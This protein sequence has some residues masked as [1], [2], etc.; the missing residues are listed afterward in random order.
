MSSCSRCDGSGFILNPNNDTHVKQCL[1]AYA[2][3]LKANLGLEI[4]SANLITESPLYKQ[5]AFDLTLK[6]LYIRGDWD[7]LLSHFKWALGC[8][9]PMFRF[10]IVTDENLKTVYVGAESYTSRPR[11][12]RDGVQTHNSLGD[13]I[14]KDVELV[15]LR[16]GFIGHKN[17]AMPGILKEALRLREGIKKIT[18]IVE[19]PES[20][21]GPGHFSYSDEV[22]KYIDRNFQVLEL[23]KKDYKPQ[24]SSYRG[25][26]PDYEE[27][28][29]V[30]PGTEPIRSRPKPRFEKP[31]S[32]LDIDIDFPSSPSPKGKK[33]RYGGSNSDGPV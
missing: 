13:L 1:C 23:T 10:K 28:E 19:D 22:A 30:S 14:G 32:S 25:F 24:V 2:K 6:D 12:E 9:G 21:F 27:G 3:A 33:K 18:W 20:P 26:Q 31:S 29:N 5:G 15:I 11:S 4:A 7:T 17:V 16:L 8:K